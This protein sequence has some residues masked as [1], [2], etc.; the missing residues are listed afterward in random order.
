MGKIR[1]TIIDS[2]TGGTINAK[3]QVI[4]SSGNYVHPKKA[5]QKVGPGQPFF[6][7]DGSFEV[8]VNRGNTRITVERGTEYNLPR[9]FSKK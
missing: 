3:A 9:I 5:I 8:D 1:A 7:T 4:D 2:E 6:Y